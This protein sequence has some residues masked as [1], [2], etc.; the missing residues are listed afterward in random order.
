MYVELCARLF[1]IFGHHAI[2]SLRFESVLA[3]LV[4][5]SVNVIVWLV[6]LTQGLCE[7]TV[8]MFQLPILSAHQSI[9]ATPLMS[10]F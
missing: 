9:R 1:T 4:K 6:A 3:I 5:S 2:V 7:A 8:A 10:G